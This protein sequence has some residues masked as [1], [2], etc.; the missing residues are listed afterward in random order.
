MTTIHQFDSAVTALD[1][2]FARRGDV[3]GCVL[4]SDRRS[5]F[6]TRKLPRALARHQMVGS[7]GQVGSCRRQRPTDPTPPTANSQPRPL[8]P[9]SNTRTAPALAA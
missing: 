6:R 5:R 4:H 3:V 7:M 1:N 8:T 9:P 2:A